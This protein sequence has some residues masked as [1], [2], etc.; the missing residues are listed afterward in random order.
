MEQNTIL[1]LWPNVVLVTKEQRLGA[2]CLNTTIWAKDDNQTALLQCLIQQPHSISGLKQL[3]MK[4]YN[5]PKEDKYA[6]LIVADFILT[7]NE[8]IQD[9][10]EDN[11]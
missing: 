1:S 6:A 8:L 4:K 7:F 2:C 5:A 3:L 9:T 11:T 10:L